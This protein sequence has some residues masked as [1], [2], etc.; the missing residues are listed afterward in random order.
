[1]PSDALS[2]EETRR[3][4]RVLELLELAVAALHRARQQLEEM[5]YPAVANS[6]SGRILSVEEVTAE[7]RAIGAPH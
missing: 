1:M 2:P 6:I 3:K 7:A 5:G 4:G